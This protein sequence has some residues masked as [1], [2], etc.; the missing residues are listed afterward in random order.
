MQLTSDLVDVGLFE[1]DIPRFCIRFVFLN[2]LLPNH[3]R[4]NKASDPKI[5]IYI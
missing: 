5:Y 2:F 3:F 1:S 4:N